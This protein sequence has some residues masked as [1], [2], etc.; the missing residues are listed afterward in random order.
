MFLKLTSFESTWLFLVVFVLRQLQ[1]CFK[2]QDALFSCG[3]LVVETQLSET[4]LDEC[5]KRRLTCVTPLRLALS[6]V[7]SEQHFA[8]CLVA[9]YHGNI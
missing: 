4:H 3:G 5:P 7:P 1:Q 2:W 8:P 6:I 9:A